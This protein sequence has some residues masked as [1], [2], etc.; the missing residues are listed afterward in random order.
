LVCISCSR[1]ACSPESVACG[2]QRWAKTFDSE[3]KDNFAMQD[4]ITSG[5]ASEMRLVL[6]PTTVALTRAGRTVNAEA[7]DLAMRGQFE[8]NRLTEAGLR[9]AIVLYKQALDLDPHYA[10]ALA[11]LA[12]GYDMLADVYAP[13]HEYHRLALDA[14]A[15]AVEQDSLLSEARAIYGYEIIA[16]TWDI[17]R[18]LREMDRGLALNPNS[19]DA[20][21]M[22]AMFHWIT[23]D[24]PKAIEY[25]ARLR[26][27]DPLSPIPVRLAADSYLWAGK[28][29]EALVEDSIAIAIDPA[30]QMMEVT[31][32][33]IEREMGRYDEAVN[34]FLAFEKAAGQPS[35]GLA[36]TYGRMRKRDDALRVLRALEAR[37]KTQ[38]VDGVFL[39]MGYAA[40]GDKPHALDWL[41]QAARD[42]SWSAR[43]LIS[44]DFPW[45]LALRD[46]PRYIA[47]R[48]QLLATTF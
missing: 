2:T 43:G 29:A 48:K 20:L 25:T 13:S 10:Q 46:E 18:G 39:A 23:G 47:L 21:F 8:K 1:G 33:S 12:F 16:A 40:M 42:K 30:V 45:F 37:R 32:A 27:V 41:E 35:W 24:E 36:M 28:Y 17:P 15:R 11:G 3:S 19:S 44:W 4:S 22:R 26:K 34:G 9:R 6:S 7:H 31:R 5:V 38:W 14:A